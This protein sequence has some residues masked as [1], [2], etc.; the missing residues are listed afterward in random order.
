MAEV[1]GRK[2]GAV[3][4]GA[5]A[6]P[7]GLGHAMRETFCAAAMAMA[8]SPCLALLFSF[9]VFFFKFYVFSNV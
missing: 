8:D 2:R 1:T 5:L 4:A 6:A 3:V 7:R 9:S